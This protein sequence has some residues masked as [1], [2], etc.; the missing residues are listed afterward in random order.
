MNKINQALS[1]V[2]TISSDFVREN[3]TL[4]FLF[5]IIA[6]MSIYLSHATAEPTTSSGIALILIGLIVFLYGVPLLKLNGLIE[7]IYNYLVDNNEDTKEINTPLRYGLICKNSFWSFTVLLAGT[8]LLNT[9]G[10]LPKITSVFADVFFFA[11]IVLGLQTKIYLAKFVDAIQK[12]KLDDALS[13][14]RS[15]Q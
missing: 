9:M 15:E 8:Y 14:Y 5:G 1:D 3:K 4:T 7:S 11:C 10:I 12:E 13:S 2:K 6:V